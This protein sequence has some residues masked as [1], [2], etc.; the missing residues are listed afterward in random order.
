MEYKK[1][2]TQEAE[3]LSAKERDPN[4][5]VTCP[6]CGAVLTYRSVG[7]SYEI[8]CPTDNCIKRTVRGI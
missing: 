4:K 6:R 3:A 7:N 8:K 2:T 5:I 1:Y